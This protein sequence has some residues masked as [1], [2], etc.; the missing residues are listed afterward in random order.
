M[1]LQWNSYIY[2]KIY[3]VHLYKIYEKNL[4]LDF[5]KASSFH[6]N[7]VLQLFEY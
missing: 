7:D 6:K 2:N 3:L 5:Q 1:I 4:Y